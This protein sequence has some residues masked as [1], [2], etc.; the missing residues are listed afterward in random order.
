VI[1][2]VSFN[3][4]LR[5]S[6]I[7]EWKCNCTAHT[8]IF[9]YNLQFV[10]DSYFLVAELDARW[11]PTTLDAPSLCISWQPF[12]WSVDWAWRTKRMRSN[13]FSFLRYVPK[14]ISTD[15]MQDHLM[16]LNDRFE[17]LCLC[18]CLVK[19]KYWDFFQVSELCTTFWGLCW[20]LTL[21]GCACILYGTRNI[22][23]HS[24]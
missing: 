18:H 1:D 6:V 5:I 2:I 8:C 20:N 19:E 24:V 10:L 21:N 4:E 15:T 22:K 3:S 13:W 12:A 9:E 14:R 23:T 17:I 16:K 7:F 11:S